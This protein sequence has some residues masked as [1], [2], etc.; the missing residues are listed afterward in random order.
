MVRLDEVPG[1]SSWAERQARRLLVP[2]EADTPDARGFWKYVYEHYHRCITLACKLARDHSGSDLRYE[3]VFQ[4]VFE[5]VASPLVYLYD[6]WCVMSPDMK[7]KFSPE[8]AEVYEKI[9]M[10]AEAFAR[11]RSQEGGP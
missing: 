6:A 5:K 3:A 11:A 7:A 10:Q 4:A 9:K 1:M 8:I 2:W